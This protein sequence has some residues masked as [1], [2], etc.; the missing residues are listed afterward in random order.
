MMSAMAL[1]DSLRDAVGA[2]HVLAKR[3][4]KRLRPVRC[5][6]RAVDRVG[7]AHHAPINQG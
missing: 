3:L 6:H 7:R 1:L 5:I 2:E 4:P